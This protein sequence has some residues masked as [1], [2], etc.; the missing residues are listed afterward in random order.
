MASDLSELIQN[1]L[2]GTLESL[3]AK[4]TNLDKTTKAHETNLQGQCVKVSTTFKFEKITSNWSFFI[5][6]LSATYILNLMMGENAEP[7][8]DINN[9]TV[10]ALNEVVSN[11]CG[12]LSTSINSSDFKDLGTVQFSLA[13]NEQV[14]GKDYAS[15]ENLFKFAIILEEK[16][17]LFYI[18]FD[19]E[20]MPYIE[21]IAASEISQAE[22]VNEEESETEDEN[23]DE[24][25]KEEDAKID[26][27]ENENEDEVEAEIEDNLDANDAKVDDK[28]ELE[29]KTNETTT[30]NENLEKDDDK[31]NEEEKEKGGK[32]KLKI[33]FSFLKK[34]NFLKVDENLSDDEKKQAKLKKIIIL[35]GSL[36]G[37]VIFI[38][39]LLYFMG[40]FEPE[41]IEKQKDTNAT[42]EKINKLVKI[43]SVQKKKHINFQ[44]SQINMNR[45]NR[46]LS[47][48]TKYEIL[49]D[50]IIEKRKIIEKEKQLKLEKFAQKNKEEPL[51]KSISKKISYKN[52]KKQKDLNKFIQ[53][54]TLKLKNFKDF[55]KKAKKA[56]AN[57]SICKNKEGRIQVFIGP[58]LNKEDRDN[59][60]KTLDEKLIKDTKK[61]NLSK[62]DFEKKCSF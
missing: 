61:L 51:V 7:S 2:S 55:I 59:I 37:V 31:N 57:L 43:K 5:P 1:G 45:L 16:E 60:L 58:F 36:F 26:E 40:A 34:L 50:D 56:N 46:K 15:T 25:S 22:K 49:E 54:P 10:D 17:I 8:E 42:K 13:G 53:I 47:L 28:E 19:E 39:I 41:V 33:S 48:L 52:D 14:D 21:T 18:A 32:K 24:N 44:M 27:T 11:I 12:G 9:E 35:V 3:L 23:S 6:A 38:G 20:I 62:E 29:E 4:K 30:E